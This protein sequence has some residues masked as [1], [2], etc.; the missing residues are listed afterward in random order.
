MSLSVKRGCALK[1]SV[2]PTDGYVTNLF[3]GMYNRKKFICFKIC[4]R[5]DLSLDPLLT[6]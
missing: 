6:V 2:V 3:D 4:T 1:L 5:F